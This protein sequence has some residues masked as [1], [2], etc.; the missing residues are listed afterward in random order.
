MTDPYAAYG[1][2][3]AIAVAFAGF[4]TVAV[5]LGQRSGGDDA[6]VDAH[7]LT[8][9]LAASLTLVVAAL[10]PGMLENLGF[11]RR[12]QLALPSI[13]VLCVI[14]VEAPGLARRNYEIR[15]APGFNWPAALTN[16]GSVILAAFA[17][18]ACALGLAGERA[19]GI[20]QLGLIGLLL[21]S[22]IMFSRVALSLLLPHNKG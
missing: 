15:N 19:A 20:Y 12:W 2:I 5:S 13:A 7:R 4:G 8:N 18:L 22:V 3:A 6:K 10:L 1:D 17:F 9:M 14:L 16:L 11:T 21:S